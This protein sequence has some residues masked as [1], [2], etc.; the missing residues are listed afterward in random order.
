ME[1]VRDVSFSFFPPVGLNDFSWHQSGLQINCYSLKTLSPIS[2]LPQKS[3]PS[4]I[5]SS[6]T[7]KSHKGDGMYVIQLKSAVHTVWM[8]KNRNLRVTIKLRDRL[9]GAVKLLSTSTICTIVPLYP[10]ANC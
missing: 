5:K 7:L 8:R 10:L 3:E 6:P 1:G 9:Q 4:V 2:K